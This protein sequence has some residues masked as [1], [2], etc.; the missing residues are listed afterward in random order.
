M[1]LKHFDKLLILKVFVFFSWVAM[2]ISI[3]SMPGE[4]EYMGKNIITFVNGMRTIFAVS[5]SS[6][7][8]LLALIYVIKKNKETT[9]K[10]LLLM[11][12][13]IY[14]ISQL[15]GLTLN[16]DRSIDLNNT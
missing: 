3:N 12:F 11:I 1:F 9:E 7:T 8:I 2:W 6:L 16:Q 14:F 4:L 15:I 13:T 10:S 5:F